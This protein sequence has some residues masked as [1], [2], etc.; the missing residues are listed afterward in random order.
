MKTALFYCFVLSSLFTEAQIN[1]AICTDHYQPISN[2]RSTD[3]RSEGMG[4]TA[5]ASFDNINTSFYNP[6][7]LS[8][9]QGIQT[10][11]TYVTYTDG[12]D[13]TYS[14]FGIGGKINRYLSFKVSHFKFDTNDPASIFGDSIHLNQSVSS[15]GIASSPINHW[16]VGANFKLL[17][18]E[19][20]VDQ[21]N[22]SYLADIGVL[23][24]YEFWNKKHLF[25]PGVSLSNFTGTDARVPATLFTSIV[26]DV[27][28]PSIARAGFRYSYTSQDWKLL[29]SLPILATT[30]QLD[31]EN[32]LSTYFRTA[33]RS[34]IEVSMLGLLH[35][36]AGYYRQS[37]DNLV[38]GQD[39]ESPAYKEY[40]EAFTFGVG[41]EAPLHK[42]YDLPF[43]IKLDYA[44]GWE[45]SYYKE[46]YYDHLEGSPRIF[47]S[48]TL[49][50]DWIL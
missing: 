47:N 28:Y 45:P 46:N 39:V 49:R 10:S 20:Y 9:I 36:R 48:F 21:N 12:I 31:Y 4:L 5:A 1:T 17:R 18:T 13:S 41:L 32:D 23:G 19:L 30:L 8:T 50:L 29:D 44:R 40:I 38:C 2:G 16:H 14:Y 42:L 43:R 25:S 6:A 7:I 15:F 26:T 35:L 33:F 37:A 3:A 24:I 22:Y 27:A 34:G 11:G